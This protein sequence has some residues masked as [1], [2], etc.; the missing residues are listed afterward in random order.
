LQT[1]SSGFGYHAFA[2]LAARAAAAG[3][4]VQRE[5]PLAP[6]DHLFFSDLH[7][8]LRQTAVFGE[9]TVSVTPKVN[10]TAGARWYDFKEDRTKVFDGVFV[11]Y[12]STPGTTKANGFAPRFIASYKAA[13]NLVF[14]A[15]ASRGFRLGGINDPLNKPICSPADTL[16]FGGHDRWK[17]ET[18]WNYE[19][20][21]K[22]RTANGRAS[23]NLA[24][25]YMD[26]RDLQLNLTAGTCSSRLV[27]NVPKATSQGLELEVTAS[28]NEHWDLAFATGLNDA[29][30]SRRD[31][32]RTVVSPRRRRRQSGN[33]LPAC[34]GARS[35]R[36]R[37]HCRSVRAV[38]RACR[39][40]RRQYVGS[41][42][43]D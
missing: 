19:A 34:P 37:I 38:R 11:G 43:A 3:T 31:Q 13:E 21:V 18:V 23:V 28:P 24:A 27:Y 32:H 30:S 36:S 10:L 26:I 42:Y 17:D 5:G 2:G 12:I 8:Q 14:N 7:Y 6:K 35:G 25:F 41:R 40:W 15:Q 1:L 22:S 33:R 39:Y 20:G 4:A 29:S 9:A 16:T